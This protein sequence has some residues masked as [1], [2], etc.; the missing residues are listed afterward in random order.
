[1]LSYH[2]LKQHLRVLRTF[3]SLD[4]DEFDTLLMPFE[5]AWEAYVSALFVRPSPRGLPKTPSEPIPGHLSRWR[6]E[7]AAHRCGKPP[8]RAGAA[9]IAASEGQPPAGD[10]G[11]PQGRFRGL[12]PEG[13]T[14]ECF[15][16][17]LYSAT[18]GC[19]HA[20]RHTW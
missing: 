7:L 3:T 17:F 12:P 10:A 19:M 9:A 11:M 18:E 15:L 1:M 16:N 13:P 2:T 20:I 8:L 4:P 5:R 14:F 6:Q